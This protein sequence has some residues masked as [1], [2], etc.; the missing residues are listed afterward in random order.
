MGGGERRKDLPTLSRMLESA[1]S[2]D[3]RIN[4]LQF[5]FWLRLRL[6]YG[7]G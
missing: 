3:E 1:L 2:A 5:K 6:I 7:W 4:S